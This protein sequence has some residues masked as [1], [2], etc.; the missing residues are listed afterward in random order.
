MRHGGKNAAM[1]DFISGVIAGLFGVIAA[2]FG[3][4]LGL[5]ALLLALAP[6]IIV[7]LILLLPVLIVVT[8]LRKI[9]ILSGPF[10][11]FV[12]ILIGIFLLMGGLHQLWRR[13]SDHVESWLQAKQQMLE[14]CRREGGDDV[15]VTMD[16]DGL[17]FTCRG[18]HKQGEQPRDA[19]I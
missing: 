4:G 12:A 10:M 16:E 7:L 9:G 15:T 6:L 2:L 11:T 1:F 8:I 19:H 14:E 3:V 17:K 5:G 18:G 13:G